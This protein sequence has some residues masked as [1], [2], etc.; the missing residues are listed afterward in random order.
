MLTILTKK[1]LLPNS[2]E[3]SIEDIGR[4]DFNWHSIMH[5]GLMRTSDAY[6]YVS[7]KKIKIIKA[8]FTI[9][10]S[11]QPKINLLTWVN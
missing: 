10:G 5:S 8:K 9:E 3:K 7:K 2:K 11:I 4:F 1:D 6:I